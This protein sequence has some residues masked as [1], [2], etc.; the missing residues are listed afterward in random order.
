ME[1]AGALPVRRGIV[2]KNAPAPVIYEQSFDPGET[3]FLF[4]DGITSHWPM[5]E[6]TH[7]QG[8]SAN[9]TA[10]IMLTTLAKENDDANS[11]HRK[12]KHVGDIAA[13]MTKSSLG[14]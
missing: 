2:G 9:E 7:L 4:S 1:M 5:D 10:Q 6:F 11:A 8:K 12:I 3:L 13:W 14:N